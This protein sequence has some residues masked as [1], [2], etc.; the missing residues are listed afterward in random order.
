MAAICEILFPEEVRLTALNLDEEPPLSGGT[1][2][3]ARYAGDR[4]R[5]FRLS[6]G[7]TPAQLAEDSGLPQSLLDRIEA[8]SHSPSRAA[9]EKITRALGMQVAD[10]DPSEERP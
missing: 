7:L 3:W 5:Q 6:Q 9:I 2:A 1:R 8:G 4:I 10:V